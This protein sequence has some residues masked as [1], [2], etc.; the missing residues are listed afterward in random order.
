MRAPQNKQHRRLEEG[1]RTDV[2]YR[3]NNWMTVLGKNGPNICEEY[4]SEMSSISII[5]TWKQDGF[6][7]FILAGVITR[8]YLTHCSQNTLFFLLFLFFIS[9][10]FSPRQLSHKPSKCSPAQ[11]RRLASQVDGTRLWETHLR[12]ILIERLPGTQGS[13][14]VQQVCVNSFV[15]FFCFSSL[16]FNPSSLL[17]I[18]TSPPLCPR[19]LLAGP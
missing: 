2:A 14:A 1:V 8:S 16:L 19:C 5:K 13:L 9:F 12:P 11:I 17:Y 7:F 4:R 6:S 3:C 15:L 10:F 18:S